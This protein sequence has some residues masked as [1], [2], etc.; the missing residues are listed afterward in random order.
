MRLLFI[1]DADRYR[2]ATSGSGPEGSS[3]LFLS[4][5]LPGISEPNACDAVI[6]PAEALASIPF[7]LAW[8]VFASGPARLMDEAFAFG[9]ADYLR[10]PW[11]A[12]ELEARARARLPLT[13]RTAAGLLR[14]RGSILEG[15]LGAKRLRPRSAALLAM[16]MCNAGRP[17]PKTAL[18][19]VLGPRSTVGRSVDMRMSRLR[20]C[21]WKVGGPA[22]ARQLRSERGASNREG[23]Y[24]LSE[25]LN[26]EADR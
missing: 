11:D 23:A 15:P 25:S 21:L 14:L 10:E 18:A 17:V 8:P 5:T 20:A 2:V 6:V 24:W 9:C 16:L 4:A 22:V 26:D 3:S 1:G 19:L 12:V 7:P 13:L